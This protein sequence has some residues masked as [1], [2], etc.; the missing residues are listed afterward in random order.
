MKNKYL[1][2]YYS[3][4]YSILYV[5]ERRFFMEDER[6]I[7]SVRVNPELHKKLKIIAIQ[8]NT[9]LQDYILKL[10]EKDMKRYEKNI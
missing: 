8:E 2:K 5:Q 1:E 6:K 3:V 9:T 4:C 7:I 10:I